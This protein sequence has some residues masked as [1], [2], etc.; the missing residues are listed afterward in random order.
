MLCW[1]AG[2][3]A[4]PWS[5]APPSLGQLKALAA[6]LVLRV[7]LPKTSCTAPRPVAGF[8]QTS[9]GA[10]GKSGFSRSRWPLAFETSELGFAWFAF[11][12]LDKA[13]RELRAPKFGLH[14]RGPQ[15]LLRWVPWEGSFRHIGSLGKPATSGKLWET[16]DCF[17]QSR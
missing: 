11:D 5:L 1:Q 3:L 15:R 13:R 7:P 14:F 4:L 2:L 8:P 16:R 17:L 10:W 6:C 9:Q 12:L